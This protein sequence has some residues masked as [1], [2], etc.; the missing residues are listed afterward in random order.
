[1]RNFILFLLILVVVIIGLSTQPVER[2]ELSIDKGGFCDARTPC[3][4]S[5]DCI[6]FPDEEQPI[7]YQGNP[8]LKCPSQQCSIGESYPLQ[9]FCS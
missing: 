5:L 6:Q 4:E 3:A 8:C 9:V 1:M 2:S 7:C